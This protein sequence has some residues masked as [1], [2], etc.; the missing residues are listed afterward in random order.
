MIH[1]V[2]QLQGEWIGYDVAA[3]FSM[4]HESH[5]HARCLHVPAI[6]VVESCSH[7]GLQPARILL[8]AVS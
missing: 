4:L 3:S 8:S 7:Q 2:Q 6:N 5:G 1:K